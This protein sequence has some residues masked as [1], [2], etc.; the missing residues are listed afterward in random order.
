MPSANKTEV[1]WQDMRVLDE[2]DRDSKA[3]QRDLSKRIGIAVG[4]T[5]KIL[6]RLIRKGHVKARAV[7]ANRLAYYL[8]PE[9]FREK[10]RLVFTYVQLTTSLFCKVR[11]LLR[12]RLHEIQQRQGINTVAIVGETERMLS[13]IFFMPGFLDWMISSHSVFQ[14]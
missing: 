14:K 2:V 1:I 5:H 10:M 3:S 7:S 8:T 9:G 6:Q 13:N 4:L 12:D 11:T